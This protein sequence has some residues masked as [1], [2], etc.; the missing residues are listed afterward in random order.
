MACQVCY[1]TITD[2]YALP[3]LRLNAW[4]AQLDGYQ[5]VMREVEG[6]G[7]LKLTDEKVLPL[8]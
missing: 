1:N 5:T 8:L 6:S 4:L 7:V 3:N 2:N